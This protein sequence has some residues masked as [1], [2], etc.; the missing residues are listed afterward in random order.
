MKFKYQAR[1]KDG[2][3]Q[4]G[5]VV[6]GNR[7][8]AANILSGHGLFILSIESAEKF[9]WY[10]AIA[11]FFGR[12][13]RKDM[14]VF[15][16]QLATLLEARIPLNNAL[17]TLYKQTSQPILK[18]AVLQL[19]EDIDA[20]LSLSQ[21]MERQD[22]VFPSFYIE[23]TRAAEITGNLDEVIGF[24]ADYSE[25]E[26]VLLSKARSAM[27]YPAI[28]ISLFIV[29]AFIMLAFVFP[30]I[31]PVFE[32]SGVELPVLTRILLGTGNFLGKWWPAIAVV[33]VALGVLLVD[34]LN[35]EEGEAL[36]DDFK[37]KFPVISKVYQPIVI[38][39][40]SNAAALLIH[41]GIP[42]AQS[43]EIIGHMVGNIL[44]RD[45]IHDVAEDVRQGKLFSESIAKYP[46]YFPPLISQMVAVGETT[47]KV[48]QIFNRLSSFYSREA[49]SLINNLVDLIQP[50]LIIGIGLLVALLFASILIPLY[51][52]TSN[53][54]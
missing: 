41:G 5:F 38:T 22:R 33:L 4:A 49:D 54:R 47:G 11:S 25:R 45:V 2:E 46:D 28:V 30:Q 37:I 19:S 51:T 21:S 40:F 16:R 17:K 32:Q 27:I 8:S 13:K 1:T 26:S 29:V 43:L 12:V 10:E 48:E 7:D 52:L 9:S 42:I 14:V 23:M 18:E 3:M 34:Y 35:T 31:G 53:I 44:Y 6:A 24:L 20:G 50:I 39:R 36:V 15:T